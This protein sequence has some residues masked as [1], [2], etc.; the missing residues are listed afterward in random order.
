MAYLAFFHFFGLALAL[1]PIEIIN[2]FPDLPKLSFG[3]KDVILVFSILPNFNEMSKVTYL[4]P[5]LVSL[6]FLTFQP[7]QFFMFTA[8]NS[9]SVNFYSPVDFSSQNVFRV[10]QP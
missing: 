4:S 9:P 1:R 8:D 6:C 10:E 5:P 7:P 3:S 2:P